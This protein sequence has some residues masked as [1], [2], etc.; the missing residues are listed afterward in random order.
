[1]AAMRDEL[2]SV[3]AMAAT[4]YNGGTALD[5][6]AADEI[7]SA[8]LAWLREC[9]LD[10]YVREHFEAGEYSRRNIEALINDIEDDA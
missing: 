5:F 2:V 10:G 6:D 1:M 3:I 8:V 7:A 9:P 4:E